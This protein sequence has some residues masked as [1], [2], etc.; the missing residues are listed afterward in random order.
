[1]ICV[2]VEFKLLFIVACNFNVAK[3]EGA[4]GD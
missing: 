2:C 1:M 3:I 4:R